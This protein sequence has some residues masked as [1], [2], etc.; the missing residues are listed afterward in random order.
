MLDEDILSF[1][2]EHPDLWL[3][4]DKI[5]DFQLLDERLGVL[6]KRMIVEVFSPEKYREAKQLGFVHLAYCI[7]SYSGFQFVRDNN[8]KMITV[9]LEG[10]RTYTSE[11][12]ELRDRGVWVLGYSAK[13]RRELK[14]YENMADMF[15]Y[16]G[17]D[18]LD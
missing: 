14:E 18:S 12:Q 9:S 4:T 1:F 6:K 8:V 3:V 15:Y 10:L 5:D 13:D 17:E 11:I 16:D 7:H 2:N